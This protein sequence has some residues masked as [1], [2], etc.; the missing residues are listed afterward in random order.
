VTRTRIAAVAV[1]TA[2][3]ALTGCTST[4]E[5]QEPAPDALY[6]DVA[7]PQ[8]LAQDEATNVLDAWFDREADTPDRSLQG[9]VQLP[10]TNPRAPGPGHSWRTSAEVVDQGDGFAYVAA[11]VCWDPR[12]TATPGACRVDGTAYVLLRE[13]DGE[14]QTKSIV[15]TPG[16]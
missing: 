14:W 15:L 8:M 11:D 3:A 4:R 12:D 1:L 16:Y 7:S 10:A 13:S 5:P 9:D 2:T 6:T